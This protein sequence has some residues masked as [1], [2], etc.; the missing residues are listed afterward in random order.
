[1]NYASQMNKLHSLIDHLKEQEKGYLDLLNSF[2]KFQQLTTNL[3]PMEAE[4]NSSTNSNSNPNLNQYQKDILDL[5]DLNESLQQQQKQNQ[6]QQNQETERGKTML[7]RRSKK[8]RFTRQK[9]TRK[10]DSSTLPDRRTCYKRNKQKCKINIHNQ[11]ISV[12]TTV[13]S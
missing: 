6:Q 7:K 11:K 1:M 13:N 9:T 4:F 3:F 5:T 8:S 2:S 12:I 10:A